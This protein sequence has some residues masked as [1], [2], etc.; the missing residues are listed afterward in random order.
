M[1][2]GPEGF[3]YQHEDEKPKKRREIPFFGALIEMIV[4]IRETIRV[5]SVC[6]ELKISDRDARVLVHFHSLTQQG[7]FNEEMILSIY[8]S[9]EDFQ[10][11]LDRL[12]GLPQ[13][14]DFLHA[15]QN[16]DELKRLGDLYFN[17]VLPALEAKKPKKTNF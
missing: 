12:S 8:Q 14:A 15:I 5:R 11:L 17:Q 7:V 1:V 16:P 9:N 3:Q 2:K 4:S 13:V 6:E 10:R